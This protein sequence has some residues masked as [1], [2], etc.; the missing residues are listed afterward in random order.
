ASARGAKVRPLGFSRQRLSSFAISLVDIPIPGLG[1]RDG[2]RAKS[3]QGLS[4]R[5]AIR[6]G[7]VNCPAGPASLRFDV[8]WLKLMPSLSRGE[9]ALMR[10]IRGFA[11][12][13]AGAVFAVL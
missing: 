1:V 11:G 2:E 8:V 13:V 7:T 4:R 6:A 12:K 9:P 10:L 5:V 3:L